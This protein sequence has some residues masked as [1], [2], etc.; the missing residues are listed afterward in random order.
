MC[1][2]GSVS[3]S[4]SLFS[5]KKIKQDSFFFWRAE[6]QLLQVL[7]LNAEHIGSTR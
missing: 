1:Y 2:Q 6:K 5:P 3:V 7:H 4:G